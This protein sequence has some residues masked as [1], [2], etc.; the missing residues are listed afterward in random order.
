MKNICAVCEGRTPISP[1]DC[2]RAEVPSSTLS[3]TRVLAHFFSQNKNDDIIIF[4]VSSPRGNDVRVLPL[5]PSIFIHFQ[6]LELLPGLTALWKTSDGQ[7]LQMVLRGEKI[8]GYL[9]VGWTGGEFKMIGS[10]AIA[11]WFDRRTGTWAVKAY[12]LTCQCNDIP[13]SKRLALRETGAQEAD[14]TLSLSQVTVQ[15]SSF[16]SGQAG[17]GQ[18]MSRSSLGWSRPFWLVPSSD[19]CP[20]NELTFVK[21][22]P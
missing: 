1:Y 3:G 7:T 20:P 9:S 12:E 17:S 21:V 10:E 11:G 22:S 8:A 15:F 4:F 13:E 16:W 6:Y 5:H 18:V 19:L 14:G 2:Y